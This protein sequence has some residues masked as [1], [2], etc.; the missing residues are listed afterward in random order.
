[1]KQKIAELINI[2]FGFRKFILMMFLYVVGIIFRVK[3][4]LSGS[5]MVNLWSNTTIAFMG[6]NGVEHIMNTVKEYINSKGQVT[7]V[8]TAP[9]P[10]GDD[11][12]E[13][14]DSAAD[15]AQAAPGGSNGS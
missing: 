10:H 9:A 14:D 1:M 12:V 6:A 15:A 4:L 2:I 11:V 8:Q 5:E 13:E 3:N 7:S